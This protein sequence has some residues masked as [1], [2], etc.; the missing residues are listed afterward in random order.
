MKTAILV[1]CCFC[2]TVAF[3][4]AGAMSNEPQVITLP[5]HPLHASQ[6]DMAMHENLL[7]NSGPDFA[8]GV[9]P[10]WEVAPEV[11]AV[12]LGD[13]ARALRK[14]HAKAKKAVVVWEK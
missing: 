7:G 13:V 5:S 9:R 14:E 6:H 10:L 3:G 11:S 4:Q 8:R 12:P 2:A 1:L